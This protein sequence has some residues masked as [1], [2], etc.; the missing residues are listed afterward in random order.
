MSKVKKID[1]EKV[2]WNAKIILEQI[3]EGIIH[4]DISALSASICKHQ[5]NLALLQDGNLL[6]DTMFM[7]WTCPM[8]QWVKQVSRSPKLKEYSRLERGSRLTCTHN[9]G[10]I[11]GNPCVL[12]ENG[13]CDEGANCCSGLWDTLNTQK[14]YLDPSIQN[15]QNMIKFMEDKLA[16]LKKVKEFEKFVFTIDVNSVAEARVLWATLNVHNKH[17][18]NQGRSL[19]LTK[20]EVEKVRDYRQIWFEE[21]DDKLVDLDIFYLEGKK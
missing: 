3:K 11:E 19:G 10:G 18:V 4:D 1:P 12:A 7:V 5:E 15:E 20:D 2:A 14:K 21:I 8:C 13:I 17:L 16:M 6:R 9:I